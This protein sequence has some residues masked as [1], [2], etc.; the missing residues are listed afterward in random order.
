MTNSTIHR[1]FA[2]ASTGNFSVGFDLLGAAF[3]PL[4]G[5]EHFGDVL[6][7]LAEQSELSLE[8][9]GR[10]RHQLPEDSRNNLVLSC[11]HAFEKAIGKRLPRLALH[12]QKNLPVGSGLGSSACSIVVACYAFNDYFGQPLSQLQLLKLMAEAEGGVSGSVHYDNV[13]PSLLGG[14]QLMLP[15]SDKLSR[16][17]P[18]FSHWRVVLSYPGTVLSTRAAREVLPRQLNLSTSIE[19]AGMLSRFVSA[20]YCQ[21]EAEAVAALQDLV[22]EPARTP[23]IPELPALRRDLMAQGVLHLGISGAGPTLFALCPDDDTATLAADYLQQHYAK[24]A[25]AS[26]RICQ[27]S[28]AGARALPQQPADFG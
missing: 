21:D 14:L 20:L 6:E 2:P 24:N 1:Y 17:M 9:S 23:L 13:A 5:T 10:Y 11:F 12:L 18:W 27:L 7:I 28:A 3:E 8:I 26:T 19:F 15:G 16:T 4:S 22:A 25:D